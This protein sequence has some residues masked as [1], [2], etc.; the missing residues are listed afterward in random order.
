[1]SLYHDPRFLRFRVD[2]EPLLAKAL[3]MAVL[4]VELLVLLSATGFVDGRGGVGSEGYAAAVLHLGVPFVVAGWLWARSLR[5]SG[6]WKV[7]GLIALVLFVLVLREGIRL[8]PEAA[9]G[10]GPSVETAL[11]TAVSFAG[12][13]D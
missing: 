6:S 4:P 9:L 2:R 13:G 3:F 1:M 11:R 8:R 7:G 10:T 12:R 5:L